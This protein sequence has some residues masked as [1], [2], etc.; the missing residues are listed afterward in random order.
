M[1]TD[2]DLRQVALDVLCRELRRTRP[3][4]VK[5]EIALACLTELRETAEDSRAQRQEWQDFVK[6][7]YARTAIQIELEKKLLP[8]GDR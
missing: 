7:E 4:K 3:G 5:C 1:P 2:S 8:R 6:E